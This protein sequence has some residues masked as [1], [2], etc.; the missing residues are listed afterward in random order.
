MLNKYEKLLEE[1]AAEDISVEENYPFKSNLLGLYV[2]H[3]IALS[4]QLTTSA[5]K[6]CILAEE[7]GH[8]H[9]S[10]GNILDLSN[11]GNAK[12]EHQTRMWAY[13][14][15]IGL[16]GLIEAYQHGCKEYHEAAAFLE[17]TEEFLREAVASYRAK[18]G[19]YTEYHGYCIIFEPYLLIGKKIQPAASDS[20]L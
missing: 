5:E 4:D 7:L 16:Q 18:Y 20:F 2:D 17:V 12:Q 10:V 6:T 9:T 8:H 1:A 11:A 14:H 13:D 19:T 3:N 15:Q